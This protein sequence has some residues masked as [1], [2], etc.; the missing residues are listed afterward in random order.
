MMKKKHD[1]NTNDHRIVKHCFAFINFAAKYLSGTFQ[2]KSY[3][4]DKRMPTMHAFKQT[5]IEHN[6]ITMHWNGSNCVQKWIF[7][8]WK[9]NR[10]GINWQKSLITRHSVRLDRV[11][12]ER[13][14]QWSVRVW[15]SRWKQDWMFRS[16]DTH[17]KMRFISLK[18]INHFISIEVLAFILFALCTFFYFGM[19]CTRTFTSACI[20]MGSFDPINV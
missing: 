12:S 16:Q 13:E 11:R 20:G 8:R 15:I 7:K 4:R 10:L 5:H 6:R 19:P 3:W 14:E 18:S 9:I 17:T 2:N 1:N